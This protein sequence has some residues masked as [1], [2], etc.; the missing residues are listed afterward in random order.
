MRIKIVNKFRFTVA[1]TIA[2]LVACTALFAAFGGFK[3]YSKDTADYHIHTV[4]NRETIWSIAEQYTPK[5]QDVRKTVYEI[6]VANGIQQNVIFV[7]QTL[8]IP[9]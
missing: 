8:K 7:G 1:L 6:K 4:D 3:A 9:K 2:L 5:G